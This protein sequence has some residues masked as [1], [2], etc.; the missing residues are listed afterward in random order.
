MY[1]GVS[2]YAYC[3]DNPINRIDPDGRWVASIF[4]QGSIGG[5]LGYGLYVVQQ[6]G[7]AYDKYGTSHFQMTGVAHITNQNL[8]GSVKNQNIVWGAEAGISGGVSI[9]WKSNSFVES[10]S[11]SNQSSAPGPKIKGSLGVGIS[12]NKNSLSLSVGLQ[13]GAS[14]NSIDMKVDE[15]VSLTKS[16]ASKVSSMTDVVTESWMVKNVTPVKDAN[17]NIIGYT[18]IVSTKNTEG[19]YINT[20]IQV[21]CG[22]LKTKNE[23]LPNN[24]WMS[25]DYYKKAINGN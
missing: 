10:L 14:L 16:E 11:G 21:N 25:N 17:G 20:G 8:S 9:D 12:G 2:P 6:T 1:Y 18:G 7:I 24:T 23:I 5:G 13:A 22:T 4:L 3:G 19:E 15:S